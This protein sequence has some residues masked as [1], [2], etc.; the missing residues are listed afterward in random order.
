MQAHAQERL[1]R[2]AGWIGLGIGIGAVVARLA[3]NRRR[4]VRR[5][6]TIKTSIT[7]RR[8]PPEVYRFW[9]DVSNL[10]Q[11]MHH[12]Q[13][14]TEAPGGHTSW[15]ARGPLGRTL[16]WR[17]DIVDDRP[18]ERIAW[19]SPEDSDL[20]N[21]GAVLLRRAPHDRGT[22]VHLTLAF[23]PPGGLIGMK[24]ARLFGEI[25]EQQLHAD[26][27]RL[28]QIL[29]TGE[30]VRSDASIH[31]GMHPARPPSKRELDEVKGALH[32]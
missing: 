21:H 12:V 16:E 26:L 18:G 5:F 3:V 4:D 25:P 24:L 27:R 20:P 6:V 30:V 14:V 8:E 9:R 22:E 31:R 28:K 32:P 13:H 17:A 29:E 19:R 10:P 23:E 1:I 15:V 2:G 11:F 7:I